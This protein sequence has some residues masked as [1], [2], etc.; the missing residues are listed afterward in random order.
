LSLTPRR[1]LALDTATENCS[2]ALWLDGELLL[3]ARMSAREHADMVLGMVDELLGEAG[4]KLAQLDALA[5][6][7]GPGGF[8]G[9]RI[10]V[11]VVQGLALGTGLPVVP[12]S[13][14]HALAWRAWQQHGWHRVQVAMD[15]RMGELYA[16][17][18]SLDQDGRIIQIGEE[19]VLAPQA[20]VLPEGQWW[21]AGPG[22]Q[23]QADALAAVAASLTALDAGIFPDAAA[24]AALAARHLRDGGAALDGTG[25]TP[26]YLRDQVARPKT[27]R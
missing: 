16:A 4:L 15:A 14:L 11:S 1:L 13:N 19:R 23:A 25:L 20:L 22:W 3:R 9:V 10:A 5:V 7:R 8:T 24:V 12:V 17:A 26:V 2:V 6:G 18:C 27:S 21:G